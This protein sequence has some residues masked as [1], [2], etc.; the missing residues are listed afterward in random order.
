MKTLKDKSLKAIIG[1]VAFTA[2]ALFATLS[3]SAQSLSSQLVDK[4]IPVSEFHSLNVADDFEVT[5]NRGTYGVRLT[6][7]EALSPYVE[8]YV[9]SKTLYLKYDEKSVP[10]E[11]KNQYK[12]KNGRT[13][14]FRV[15]V[16]APELQSLTLADNATFYTVE[17]FS[18]SQFE[19]SAA[20]KSQ[21]KNLS[22]TANSAKLDLKKNAAVTLKLE[23]ERGVEAATD[24]SA[25][26]NLNF[27]GKE[28]ALN[29]SGSSVVVANGPC[30]TLNIF[31][32]GSSEVSV[33][34][35][36]KQVSLDT[37]GSS[38]VVLTGKAVS[39][40]VDGKRSSNVDAFAMPLETVEANLANTANVTVT[41]SQKVV[42]NL[43]G[44]SAL[45]YSGKPV[46]ELV[47][48]VKST[49]A[50]YGTK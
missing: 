50:P 5:L 34:S 36:T 48:V 1:M 25:N 27:T 29:T 18:A 40:K 49:L 41:V 35:E 23:T 8:V 3:A 39:M 30:T 19:L 10:K 16:Y 24:N 11:V 21:V 33:T 22:V 47:K 43:V 9:K 2:V 46:I 14:V 20:G 12:G 17:Q 26:L 45:Y 32:S 7:D 38:K 13:P 31:S 44:G 37:E 15:V 42:A 28:L 4:D 6:V